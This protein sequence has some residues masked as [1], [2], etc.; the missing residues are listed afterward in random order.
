MFFYCL[1]DGLFCTLRLQ[2]NQKVFAM[3]ILHERHERAGR[4]RVVSPRRRA[5]RAGHLRVRRRAEVCRVP[6]QAPTAHVRRAGPRCDA[7]AQKAACEIEVEH[8]PTAP[9]RTRAFE[10]PP[11]LQLV[12]RAPHPLH[13]LHFVQPCELQQLVQQPF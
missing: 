13:C 4:L 11:R 6:R 12:P 2:N 7:L 5:E 10:P 9:M 3:Q 1:N 8:R